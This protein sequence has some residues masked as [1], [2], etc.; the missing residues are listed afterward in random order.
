VRLPKLQVKINEAV[1]LQAAYVDATAARLA[2]SAVQ[3]AIEA[4]DAAAR[5]A[6][7]ASLK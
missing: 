5:A 1:A 3:A 2:T 6:V 4:A 7:A